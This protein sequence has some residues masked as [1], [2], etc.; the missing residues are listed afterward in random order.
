MEYVHGKKITELSPLARMEFDGAAL[1]EELFRAYLEQILVRRLFPRRS[2]SG[3][4][5]HHGRLSDR[6]DRSRHGRPHHAGIAGGACCNCCSRFQKAAAK[7]PPISRSRSANRKEDFD[8]EGIHR[9][10]RRNRRATENATVE[11]MQVGR[12]VLEV[13]QTSAR[14]RHSC[15]AELTMLGKT[16]LNLDQVGRAHRAG[17]RSERVDPAQCRRRSCNNV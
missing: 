7:K 13:T 6:A 11:Q 8:G 4:C 1:A 17:V 5:F 15:A 10:D 12:L 14:K 9:R 3:Q 2:A 16:L